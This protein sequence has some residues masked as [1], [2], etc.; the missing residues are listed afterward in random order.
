MTTTLEEKLQKG[1]MVLVGEA[2]RFE[3]RATCPLYQAM[4]VLEGNGISYR[5]H[6]D[7]NKQAEGLPMLMGICV[8]REDAARAPP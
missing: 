7:P 6:E 2:D 4:E 1:E 8:G 5:L 3:P